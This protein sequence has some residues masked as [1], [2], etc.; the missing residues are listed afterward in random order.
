MRIYAV[1]QGAKEKFQAHIDQIL[2]LFM[3][4]DGP[5]QDLKTFQHFGAFDGWIGYTTPS[6]SHLGRAETSDQA[7]VYLDA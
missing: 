7:G 3:S 5:L 6:T 4:E 1:A 2:P